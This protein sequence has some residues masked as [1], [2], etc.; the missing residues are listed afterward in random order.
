[1]KRR[2]IL[3]LAAVVAALVT[4]F[5]AGARVHA[6]D[7]ST[8]APLVTG[9]ILLNWDFQEWQG[10][11][12]ASWICMAPV[13][14]GPENEKGLEIAPAQ[15]AGHV[16]QRFDAQAFKA[17]DALRFEVSAKCAEP[18]ALAV[19]IWVVYKGE[20]PQKMEFR[21]FHP[22]DAQ[23]HVLPVTANIGNKPLERVDFLMSVSDKAAQPIQIRSGRA[24]I[25]PEP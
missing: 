12:P 7:S 11:K 23:W 5:A 6:Q 8:P 17:G 13:R 14:K 20:P 24:W 10:E 3:L 25:I 1:M 9:E 19:V 2:P 4:L 21:Q 16:Y 22:G 15:K 18:Q